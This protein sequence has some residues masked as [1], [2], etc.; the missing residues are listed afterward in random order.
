MPEP[1]LPPSAPFPAPIVHVALTVSDL[2]RS[3]EWYTALFG[4]PPAHRGELL[5]DTPHHYALAVWRV[6]NLGLHH[7]LGRSEDLSFSE[8]RPGLDHLAFDCDSVDELRSWADHLDRLGIERGDILEEPY[9]YGL[10][11]RDP[12]N[13]A[14]E[15]FARRS[16]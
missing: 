16:Q 4:E 12:D 5:R 13:I 2:D 15:F 8:R 10:A 6:P 11:F 1:N 14:L 9:G 7:H 3:V